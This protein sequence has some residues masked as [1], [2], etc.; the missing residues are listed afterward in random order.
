M[1]ANHPDFN[2]V[3]KLYMSH[4]VEQ[5]VA[6]MAATNCIGANLQDANN[7]FTNSS[8]HPSGFGFVASFSFYGVPQDS[9][10]WWAVETELAAIKAVKKPAGE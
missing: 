2:K 6:I 1:K 10:F 7:R 4:G 5:T 8:Y 3:V 9:G